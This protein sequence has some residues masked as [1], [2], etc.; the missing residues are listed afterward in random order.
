[1]WSNC[2]PNVLSGDCTED[3][4]KASTVSEQTAEVEPGGPIPPGGKTCIVVTCDAKYVTGSDESGL[5]GPWPVF[6][7][8]C[9]ALGSLTLLI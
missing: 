4:Q 7:A 8:L 6:S 9:V 5:W 2:G 1:M 3:R